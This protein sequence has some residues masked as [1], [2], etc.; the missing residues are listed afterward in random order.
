MKRIIAACCA[1]V[2]STSAYA[3]S[4]TG[5]ANWASIGLNTCKFRTNDNDIAAVVPAAVFRVAPCRS[6]MTIRNNRNG[7]IVRVRI[8]G[9]SATSNFE[10]TPAAYQSIANLTDSS[11]PISW[12]N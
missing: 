1:V 5:V 11:I 4:G 10:L 2:I 9:Q 8:D 6:S 3:A 12:S 7:K